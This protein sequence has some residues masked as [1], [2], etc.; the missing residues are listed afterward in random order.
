VASEAWKAVAG[1]TAPI[2]RFAGFPD[3]RLRATAL[4]SLL[5]SEILAEIDD[6]AELKLVLYLFWRLG[7]TRRAPRFLTR[8]E[9]EADVSIRRGLD[10]H[11][12]EALARALDRVVA[13]GVL[14]R[15]QIEW[16]ETREECYFLNTGGGRRTV[17]DLESGKLDLGQVVLP[18]E[19]DRRDERTNV[20]RLYEENVGLVTPL[21]AE[22]L[23]EAEREYPGEWIEDAFRLA[24]AYN[25]R[26]W[27]YVERI[28]QRWATEGKDDEAHR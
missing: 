13:R 27:R 1:A 21:I 6:L 9:I 19:P 25:R 20:F 5:F 2:R 8:R 12:K 24:V 22:Q 4:P 14:L 3:G 17:R 23:A 15:R 18:E 26:S 11:G 28:L 7:Q 10:V 16:G